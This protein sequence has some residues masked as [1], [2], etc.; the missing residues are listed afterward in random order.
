MFF[1]VLDIWIWDNFKH[2][3]LAQRQT[4][5]WVLFLEIAESMIIKVF[6]ICSLFFF[7]LLNKIP[8]KKKSLK[9]GLFL[10]CKRIQ[11]LKCVYIQ[12]KVLHINHKIKLKY[13]LLF[14]IK[15]K[16]EFIM[17]SLFLSQFQVSQ[18]KLVQRNINLGLHIPIWDQDLYIHISIYVCMYTLIVDFLL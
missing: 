6:L 5:F 3:N 2:K 8:I 17:F 15:F 12:K 13:K 11:H 14:D 16:I 18:R 7:C 9:N 10:T 4:P 1:F